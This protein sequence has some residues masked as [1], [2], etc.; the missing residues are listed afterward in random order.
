MLITRLVDA[1]AFPPGINILV[2]LLGLA[3]LGRRR[4]LG[5]MLLGLGIVSLYLLATPRLSVALIDTLQGYPAVVLD[6]ARQSGAQ[7]VVVLG[8]GRHSDTPEYG[9]D[10]LSARAL[11]RLRYAVRLGRAT[12]LPVLATGGDPY[13]GGKAESVLMREAATADF[14]FR[15]RWTEERS[16]TT[17]ENAIYSAKLLRAEGIRRI[18]LVSHAWHLPRAVRVFERAGFTVTPAPTIY[19]RLGPASRGWKGWL[20]EAGAL[21]T[22]TLALHEWVGGIWYDLRHAGVSPA[23]SAP[24]D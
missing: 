8:A 24:Q 14:Q 20:P 6:T 22:S 5:A 12:G 4:L 21:L 10:T 7:A 18:L 1:L 19:E 15:L 23:Q 2:I 9:G 3:A 13:H 17:E 16:R 11:E